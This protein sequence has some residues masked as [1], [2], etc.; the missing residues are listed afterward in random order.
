[1]ICP[2][3]KCT[4]CF[5]CVNICPKNCIQMKEDHFGYVYPEVDQ[6]LCIHCNLCDKVCPSNHPIQANQPMNAY[7][8]WVLDEEQRKLS[9][10]G[11]LATLVSK[12]LIENRGI[13]FGAAYQD[14]EIQHIRID[15][16]KDLDKIRGSKYVHSYLKFAYREIKNYLKQDKKVLFIG[17]PCQVAGLK[18]FLGKEESNLYTIDIVCHGVPSQKLLKEELK[19]FE[20]YDKV[21]FRDQNG[22][23]LTVFNKGVIIKSIP[24]YKSLYYQAFLDS[25]TYRENC[26]TCPYAN[27]QRLGDLTLGDFWGL[28]DLKSEKKDEDKG[29]SLVLVNTEKGTTLLHSV[30]SKLFLEERSINE[31]IAGNSQ[32]RHSSKVHKNRDVFLGQYLKIGYRGALEEA[33]EYNSVKNRL[34]RIISS[35]SL[36][37]GLIKRI[38]NS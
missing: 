24:S 2:A 14:K 27:S 13:V 33:L 32:L 26:Y 21:L 31:A 18:S 25:L 16:V 37:M 11:G 30:D 1:M 36:L 34:K 7:A 6:D 3:E 22:F 5:A 35:N 9:T 28:G 12:F 20:P 29:I 15:D 8:S 10:S 17:T 23:N 4:G 19:D 38:K